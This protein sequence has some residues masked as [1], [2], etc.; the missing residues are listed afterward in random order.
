VI[1]GV[2]L[3]LDALACG[4]DVEEVIVDDRLAPTVLAELERHHVPLHRAPE[5]ALAKATSTTTA[6]PAA[7]IARQ[8]ARHASE[9]VA[10]ST[11][12][13]VLVGVGDPGN[14]G[15][16]LRTAEAAGARAVLFCDGSVD[17]YNP[18][19]VRASAG[20]LFR[21]PVS[22]GDAVEVLEA[23]R[24]AG[25]ARIATATRRGP[26]PDEVDLAGPF[27]LVL[28]NEAHGLPELLHAHVDSWVSVPMVGR[29]ESLNV[30]MTGAAVCF[31]ALRQR[32]AQG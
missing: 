30:A 2:T 10:D 1:E 4:V 8:V 9:L 14:A 15:T 13:L 18:K 6:Q 19:C 22:T 25:V 28:G 7:A 29:V 26:A 11:L 12:T 27:A 24:G 16:L 20:S 5:G 32:R 21:V 31:E 23:C 3:V 17:P